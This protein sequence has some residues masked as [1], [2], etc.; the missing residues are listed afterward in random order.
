MALFKVVGDRYHVTHKWVTGIMK[1]C[2]DSFCNYDFAMY[3]VEDDDREIGNEIDFDRVYI[4]KEKS[5]EHHESES[6]IVWG[7]FKL[8]K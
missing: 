1:E 4:T 7:N 3:L 6:N 5:S 8:G 2:V